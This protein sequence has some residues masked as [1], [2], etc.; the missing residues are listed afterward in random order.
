MLPSASTFVTRTA[1]GY[2]AVQGDGPF[3]LVAINLLAGDV[4][5]VINTVLEADG[6]IAGPLGA[7][8]PNPD[9]SG[10]WR[11]YPYDGSAPAGGPVQAPAGASTCSSRA[12]T[13]SAGPRRN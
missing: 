7:A 11:C 4:T 5:T 13:S 3:D 9:V 12:S 2:L 6:I 10:E 1:T 8:A